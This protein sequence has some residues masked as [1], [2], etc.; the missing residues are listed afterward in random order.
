MMAT[1]IMRKGKFLQDLGVRFSSGW[2]QS[3]T[4]LRCLCG[5]VCEDKFSARERTL[6]NA[7]FVSRPFSMG[8][9]RYSQVR[10]DCV[11]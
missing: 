1:K 3:F 9:A 5:V 10:I 6:L 8:T 7:K 4:H 11:K 2:R